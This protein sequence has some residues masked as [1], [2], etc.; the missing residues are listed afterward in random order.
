MRL[1]KP[2][3]RVITT[4]IAA[5]AL[6]ALAAGAP[7]AN[8]ASIPE[9]IGP[10]KATSL[11]KELGTTKTAGTFIDRSDTTVVNVTSADAADA[12]RNAGGTPRMVEHSTAQLTS[13][14]KSM[15]DAGLV[16]GTSWAVDPKSNTVTVTTDDSVS[17]AE[18]AEVKSAVKQFGDKVRLRETA[19]TYSTKITGGD[20]IWGDGARCSLGFNVV[21]NDDADKHAFLTAGHC[22]NEIPTWTEDQGGQT[23]LGDTTDSRFP[24]VDYAI[25]DY[26]EGYTD[27]PS[28]VGEQA[29]DSA[30]TPTVGEQVTRRGSTSGIHEG[31]VTA[32]DATVRYPE[33]TVHGLI[34]TTVCA[35]PGDSG[36]PLYADST[37]YGLTS[38]ASG[39]CTSGGE[40]F[41]QP[42]EPVLEE[43]NVS[44]G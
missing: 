21:Y 20:A 43:Y 38:G 33:G 19:G 22:G 28:Q 37:A 6:V 3:P 25:V 13:V 44:I 11:A 16:A 40:T 18:L 35:E 34:Q 4:G 24:N 17:K 23:V 42:V 14:K 32:L 2:S 1:I 7:A 9:D 29:I 31:E 39:D 10:K 36:G 5:S 41:F 30:G 26:T 27:Y 15:D 12:V 8:A